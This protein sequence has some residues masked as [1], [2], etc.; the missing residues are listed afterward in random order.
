MISIHAP[1]RGA[2]QRPEG[3]PSQAGIS[4]HA[5]ARGA[6]TG[7]D[8]NTHKV[9]ISI[10]APARGAT[11]C[12]GIVPPAGSNFNP[13]SREGSDGG[14]AKK[15]QS[16]NQ[17]QSTLPRGER[18]PL[19]SIAGS[20]WNFNPRSREGSDPK[21]Q[22]QPNARI[23]FNPRSREGSD[24]SRPAGSTT[25]PYFNPRSREGS[26]RAL[27]CGRCRHK[28]FNPRSREG[29]DAGRGQTN[30]ILQRISIHAP[31]RGATFWASLSICP[32]IF[33]STLPRGERPYRLSP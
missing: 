19:A 3:L 11:V 22:A 33:Q 28:D 27:R 13:R 24:G 20:G 12:W 26:D 6:T 32:V 18:Q 16:I 8:G 25:T 1:A 2:T 30:H 4:I 10:H 5:P 31:A 9:V 7:S 14:R 21:P 23:Y 15:W 29:S 17:F